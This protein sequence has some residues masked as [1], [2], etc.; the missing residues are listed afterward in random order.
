[1]A[2]L[3]PKDESELRDMLFTAVE[4]QGGPV[5]VRYPRGNGVGVPLK[6]GFDLIPFGKGETLRA[7]TDVALL[8]IG[9][10]TN[11]AMKA[12]E[13][14]AKEGI[15]AEVVNMRFVK[16][17]DGDLLRAVALRIP[18]V[19]TIED[20]VVTGGFGSAVSEFFASDGVTGVRHLSLGIPDRFVDHGTPQE[21][22]ADL[23]LDPEGIARSVASFLSGARRNAS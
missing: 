5:A 22:Y 21:L 15:S 1:M 23:G 10:M 4:H 16:P 6:E 12:A 14:L 2:I 20:N 11:A 13:L 18:A 17:I 8:G 7:G 3:A 19:V 9:T